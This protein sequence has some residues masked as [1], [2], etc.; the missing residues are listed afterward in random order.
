[1]EEADKWGKENNWEIAYTNLFDRAQQT[2][3]KTWD[4]Q[5]KRGSKAVHDDL[6]YISMMFNLQYSLQCEAWVCTLASNSCRLIDELRATLGG[7]ANRFYADLSIETCAAPPCIE[8]HG[9]ITQWGERRHLRHRQLSELE[10]HRF[11]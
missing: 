10:M 6:E 3:F 1:M 7:K 5:H 8:D 11:D 4:E 2:A 9:Y